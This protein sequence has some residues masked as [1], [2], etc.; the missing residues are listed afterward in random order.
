[1]AVLDARALGE[2]DAE[3]GAVQ[4]GLDVVGGQRVAGEQDVDVAGVDQPHHGRG[5]AGVDDGGAAD[6]EDPLPGRLDLAHPLG[7]LAHQQRLRLLAGHRRVHEPEGLLLAARRGAGAAPPG[8]RWRRRPP[9]PGPHVADRHG[10]HAGRRPVDDQPAVHLR[11][12]HPQPLAVQP[13]QGLEVGGGV[14]VVGEDAVRSARAGES[15]SPGST[16]LTPWVCSRISIRCSSVGVLG[17]DRDQG[18]RLVLVLAAEV[19]AVDPVVAAVLEDVVE[20]PG[21]DAGVHEVAGE[22]DGGWS[23]QRSPDAR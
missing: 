17:A 18:A 21:E 3:R 2:V 7:D 22:L 4:R 16:W 6:P 8:R 23:A 20:H 10:A 15:P 19:E 13:H 12:A 14:E 5:G 11:A 9:A 1:M